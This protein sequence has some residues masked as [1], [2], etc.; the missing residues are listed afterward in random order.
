MLI[1]HQVRTGRRD[2]P[3]SALLPSL[4]RNRLADL[5]AERLH[6]HVVGR[7][8]AAERELIP[9]PLALECPAAAAHRR[10]GDLRFAQRADD[11]ALGPIRLFGADALRR[12]EIANLLEARIRI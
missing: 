4:L 11:G 8:L 10:G 9:L 3:Q 12:F 2:S 1:G 7:G 5:V 6:L